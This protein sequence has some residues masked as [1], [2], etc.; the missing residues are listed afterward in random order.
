MGE[1]CPVGRVDGTWL[2]VDG[3]GVWEV[4]GSSFLIG[5]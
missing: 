3:T 5:A 1:D 4:A 2:G